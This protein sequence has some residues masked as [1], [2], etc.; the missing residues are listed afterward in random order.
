MNLLMNN[1]GKC[2]WRGHPVQPDRPFEAPRPPHTTHPLSSEKIRERL[3]FTFWGIVGFIVG[4]WVPLSIGV[5]PVWTPRPPQHPLQAQ[6][7]SRARRCRCRRRCQILE[8]AVASYADTY[9]RIAVGRHSSVAITVDPQHPT[10]IPEIR[11]LGAESVIRPL[12]DSLN[13]HLLQWDFGR[14]L[15]DNLLHVLGLEAFPRPEDRRAADE[16]A[17]ECGICYVYHLDGASPDRV[18]ENPK[19]SRPFHS[20][21][22][23]EWLRAVPGTRQSFDTLFGECV[24]CQESITVKVVVN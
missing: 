24:Y 3:N 22:L 2:L 9:R 12:N 17:V 15:L 14:S 13:R 19:C 6:P 23:A 7:E 5:P 4:F 20:A 8:P 21:C 16:D 10:A 18:C 11:F 1:D